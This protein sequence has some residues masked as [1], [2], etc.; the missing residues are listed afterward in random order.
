MKIYVSHSRHFDYLN[1]VYGPIRESSLNT[2]YDFFLPH[3]DGLDRNSKDQ[4]KI[5]D[6]VLAEVS[7]PSI[8]Q[9]IELGWAEMMNVPIICVYKEGFAV[10]SALQHVTNNLISYS[11]A[12]DMLAKVSTVLS[13]STHSHVL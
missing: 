5:S 9:G 12:Q 8:G 6:F 4:I 3:E 10:T 2:E 11:N 7:V 13:A 1:E